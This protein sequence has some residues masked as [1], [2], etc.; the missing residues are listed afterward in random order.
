MSDLH[1]FTRDD[2]CCVASWKSVILLIVKKELRMEGIQAWVRAIDF[3]TRKSPTGYACITV[4]EEKAAMLQRAE[5][6]TLVKVGKTKMQLCASSAVVIE[7]VGFVSATKRSIIATLN[8]LNRQPFPNRAFKSRVEAIEA[9]APDIPLFNGA[10]VRT[11]DL[12][13]VLTGLAS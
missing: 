2:R 10:P 5:S 11:L 6:R 8:L 3:T 13:K 1:I 9:L 12:D 4:I 7:G